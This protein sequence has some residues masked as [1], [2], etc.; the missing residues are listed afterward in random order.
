[1]RSSAFFVVGVTLSGCS[2][3][4]PVAPPPATPTPAVA[5]PST[6]APPPDLAAWLSEELPPGA[7]LRIDGARLRGSPLF[8]AVT[9]VAKQAGAMAPV[10]AASA[11]C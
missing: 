2:A 9:E 7:T 5:G 3:G 10:E 8:L 11:A 6:P 1:M 4:A